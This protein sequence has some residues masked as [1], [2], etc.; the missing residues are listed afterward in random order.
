MTIKTILVSLDGTET[1]DAVLATAFAVVRRLGVHADVLHVRT[2]STDAVPA[3]GEA[4]TSRMVDDLVSSSHA[5]AEARAT[6]ART[7]F[8]DFCARNKIPITDEKPTGQGISARWIEET[9]RKDKV[10]AHRG[11]LADLVVVGRPTRSANV[12]SS[13]VVNALFDTGRPVLVV[14]PEAPET[15]GGKIAIAWNG[16]AECARAIGGA[17]N[18]FSHANG[19]VILTAEGDRVPH[20]VVE[21]LADYLVFHGIDAEQKIIAKTP[22]AHLGGGSLLDAC[23]STGADLL[24]MGAYRVSRFREMILGNATQQVLENTTLPVL[25]G[26]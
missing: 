21:D 14:P 13:M 15:V 5:D 6:T 25:M 17:T 10:M 26:H 8:E 7:H 4:M 19:V 24:V 11:R 23:A 18:F 2:D 20:S 9:G 1:T 16:S 3:F 12:T 22:E